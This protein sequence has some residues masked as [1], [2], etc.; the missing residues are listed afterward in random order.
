MTEQIVGGTDCRRPKRFLSST[1]PRGPLLLPNILEP[2]NAKSRQ[3]L[4]SESVMVNFGCNVTGSRTVIL[5]LWQ[6]FT[7]QF[8]TAAKSQL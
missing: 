6:V 7:L 2:E 1:C 5:N 8:M 4:V 3:S